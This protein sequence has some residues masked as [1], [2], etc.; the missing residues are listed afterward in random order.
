MFSLFKKATPDAVRPETAGARA[1]FSLIEVLI[2]TAILLVIV[3]MVS[4]VFQQQAGA[5]QS[6]Q[7]RMNGQAALRNVMGMISRDL[8]LAVDS[9]NYPGVPP[10]SFSGGSIS[11][12]ATTG[13]VGDGSGNSV[14][15]ALQRIEYNVSGRIVKRRVSDV[16]LGNGG[17][18]GVS[19]GKTANINGSE[20]LLEVSFEPDFDSDD[21]IR[22]LPRSVKITATYQGKGRASLV[23]GQSAGEDR[24][25]DTEDDILVGQGAGD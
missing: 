11:F 2:S 24:Q 19:G 3:M 23:S 12:L 7:D 15:T 25:Y 10:N 6:G 4:L 18:W 13:V 9:E 21:K 14:K 22:T 8:S 16:V 17:Q 5:I 20:S 1:A